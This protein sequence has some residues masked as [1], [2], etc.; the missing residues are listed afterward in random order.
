MNAT[1]N[2]CINYQLTP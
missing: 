2:M 1:T